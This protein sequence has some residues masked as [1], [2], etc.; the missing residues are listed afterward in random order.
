M[1]IPISYKDDRYAAKHILLVAAEKETVHIAE[2]AE[3]AI[4][5][6]EERFLIEPANLKPQVF[7]RLTANWVE[8]TVRFLCK[9]HEIRGL[10][11]RMSRKII[12]HLDMAKIGIASAIYDIVGLP[13]IQVRFEGEQCMEG[14]TRL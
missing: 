10:K 9:D 12:H 8:L 13:P 4:K 6:L 1:H 3:P 2:M 14:A 7:S 11:D 5:M